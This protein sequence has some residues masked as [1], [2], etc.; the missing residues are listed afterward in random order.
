MGLG[1]VHSIFKFKG[2]LVGKTATN[3]LTGFYQSLPPLGYRHQ[4]PNDNP[5]PGVKKT[6]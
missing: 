1:T 4:S 3:N 6:D 5:S 2:P